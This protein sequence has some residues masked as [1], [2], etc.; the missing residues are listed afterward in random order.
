MKKAGW[1]LLAVGLVQ[2]VFGQMRDF[3]DQQ[4]RTVR[5]EPVSWNRISGQLTVKMEDGRRVS[6]DPAVFCEEDRQFIQRWREDE[7]FLNER[8]LQFTVQ[9]KRLDR[10]SETKEIKSSRD[11]SGTVKI[12]IDKIG[13][14]LVFENKGASD[15][16]ELTVEY[17]L[18]YEKEE[19]GSTADAVVKYE[20]G[21]EVLRDLRYGQPVSVPTKGADITT[22]KL[23]SGWTWKNNAPTKSRDQVLGVWVKFSKPA[24]DGGRLEREFCSPSNLKEKHRW[25]LVPQEEPKKKKHRAE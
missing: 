4:G 10:R 21:R 18:F 12:E 8:Y 7:I 5:I 14:D 13:Y 15:L 19:F 2:G 6:V 25:D 3:R 24:A 1:F 16:S 22:Y 20:V 11:E 23:P 9:K 17:M